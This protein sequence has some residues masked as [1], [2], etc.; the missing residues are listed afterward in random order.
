MPDL[1]SMLLRRSLGALKPGGSSC[2]TCERTP[3]AG[4]RLHEL[5]SGTLLCDL[6]FGALPDEHR[7]AVRSQ[8]VGASERRLAVAPKAA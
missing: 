8:R 4:E 5:D 1:G 6:C 3:L 2:A 7:L